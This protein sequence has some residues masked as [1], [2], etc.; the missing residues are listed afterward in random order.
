MTDI[1]KTD[2]GR[3][4]VI[5][6][7]ASR[8]TFS[9]SFKS[10]H[11][12]SPHRVMSHTPLSGVL[13]APSGHREEFLCADVASIAGRLREAAAAARRGESGSF[14]HESPSRHFRFRSV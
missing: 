8:V 6:K 2:N 3:D 4:D 13:Q 14:P 5:S 1:D 10:E 12:D 9:F 7:G 11:Y